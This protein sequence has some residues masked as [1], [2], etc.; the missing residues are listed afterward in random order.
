MGRLVLNIFNTMPLQ[1][2]C[3]LQSI[4]SKEGRFPEATGRRKARLCVQNFFYPCWNKE[5]TKEEEKK[6]KELKEKKEEKEGPLWLWAGAGLDCVFKTFS[7][8]I[9]RRRRRR[10]PWGCG[11]V[12]G[13]AV[14]ST[15]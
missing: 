7:P 8:Y 10:T 5:E 13:S 11:P 9:E 14:C 3:T 1:I 4:V 12:Q 2:A 6:E 15:D